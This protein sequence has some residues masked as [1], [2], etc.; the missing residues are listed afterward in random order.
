M[1]KGNQ[2]A[3]GLTEFVDIFPTLTELVG[4]PTP[5]SLAGKSLV[6]VLKNPSFEVKSFTQSQYPR[7]GDKIMGYTI[8]TKRYRYV[9]WYEQNYR[10][11]SILSTSKP[12]AVELYDYQKDALETENL[13]L[14]TEYKSI[15]KGHEKMMSE[16]LANQ[17][18]SR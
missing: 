17:K 9:A 10:N 1:F 6:P 12:V 3:Q 2:K 16:F 4:L 14:K 18:Q 5:L 11:V 8:R 7:K 15:L 13:A